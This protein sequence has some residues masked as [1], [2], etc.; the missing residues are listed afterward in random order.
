MVRSP[1]TVLVDKPNQRSFVPKAMKY[2][3]LVLDFVKML[4]SGWCQ[5]Q[6]KLVAKFSRPDPILVT[7][8]C[9]FSA[10]ISKFLPLVF[11]V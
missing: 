4:A 6:P 11:Q 8:I 3:P 1:R 2:R 10:L 7:N 9:E 5:V